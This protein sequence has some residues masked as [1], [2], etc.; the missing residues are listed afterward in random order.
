MHNIKKD[1][2]L[3]EMIDTKRELIDT[4][5][6]EL[7]EALKLG[8]NKRKFLLDRPFKERRLRKEHFDDEPTMDSI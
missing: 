4:K 7:R 1:H 2:Y 3:R 8:T 6:F 5:G